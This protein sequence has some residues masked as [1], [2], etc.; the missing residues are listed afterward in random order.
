MN[1]PATYNTLRDSRDLPEVL[2]EARAQATQAGASSNA[3]RK[4]PV[5]QKLLLVAV[6]ALVLTGL[7]YPVENVVV[8]SGQVI[9]SDRVK[10]VQH[11]EGGIVTVVR[12]KEGQSVTQ[13]QPL[14]EIDLGGNSLNLE[15]L[16]ARRSPHAPSRLACRPRVRA[17]A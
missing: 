9:P 3:P 5:K 10:S 13:G 8:A 1:H 12:V 6:G 14:L 4:M 2:R 17:V 16:T 15:Q 11:L 7:F